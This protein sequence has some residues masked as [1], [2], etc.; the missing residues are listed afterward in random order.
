M[1]NLVFER[2]GCGFAILYQWRRGICPEMNIWSRASFAG[3]H[4]RP[5]NPEGVFNAVNLRPPENACDERNH[6]VVIAPPTY[7]KLFR[8]AVPIVHERHDEVDL[9]IYR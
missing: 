1:L 9:G 4:L 3:L 7:L 5:I 6:G 2:L 8:N